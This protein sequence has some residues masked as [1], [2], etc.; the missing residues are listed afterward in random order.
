MKRSILL[1]LVLFS[2]TAFSQKGITV[3]Y[4]QLEYENG[5]WNPLGPGYL[6]FYKDS[7]E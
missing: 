7:I 3:Q 1:I 5:R 2:F 4:E 6:V